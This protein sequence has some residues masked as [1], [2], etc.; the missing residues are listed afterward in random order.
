M[1]SLAFAQHPYA[2]AL[3]CILYAIGIVY[4][5]V[6]LVTPRSPER[7]TAGDEDGA[8]VSHGEAK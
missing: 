5:T 3:G 2:T 4:L 1:T 8:S 6:F 7:E